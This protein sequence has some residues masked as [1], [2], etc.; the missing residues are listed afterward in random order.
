MLI[1]AE[2]PI[3]DDDFKTDLYCV[4]L[5]IFKIQILQALKNFSCFWCAAGTFI[6]RKFMKVTVKYARILYNHSQ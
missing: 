4:L 1:K 2:P 6:G 3:K 5:C